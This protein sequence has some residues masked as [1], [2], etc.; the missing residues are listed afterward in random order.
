VGG[1]VE[2]SS[3]Q[4]TVL[5]ASSAPTAMRAKYFRAVARVLIAVSLVR[6]PSERDDTPTGPSCESIEYAEYAGY[7]RIGGTA[8]IAMAWKLRGIV[9]SLAGNQRVD[10]HTAS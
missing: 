9:I 4:V 10:A 7:G 8:Q 6:D 2:S 1:C 5:L 3:E